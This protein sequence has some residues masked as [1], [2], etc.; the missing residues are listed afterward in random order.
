MYFL[1]SSEYKT[2][3]VMVQNRKYSERNGNLVFGD[4]CDLSYTKIRLIRL[5]NKRIELVYFR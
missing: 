5:G 4:E 3:S 1:T 2:Q